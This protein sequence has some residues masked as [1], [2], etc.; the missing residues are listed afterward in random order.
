MHSQKQ[1]ALLVVGIVAGL[2]L[3]AAAQARGTG[4]SLAVCEISGDGETMAALLKHCLA[5]ALAACAMTSLGLPATAQTERRDL[6]VLA[7]EGLIRGLQ[8]ES[9][10]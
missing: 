10:A 3:V 6:P 5:G 9:L 2:G 1:L 8:V 4:A 7:F